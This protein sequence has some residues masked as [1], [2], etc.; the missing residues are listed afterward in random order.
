MEIS[1]LEAS[2]LQIS[3]MKPE[4]WPSS[5]QIQHPDLYYRQYIGA[6][7]DRKKLIYINAFCQDPPPQIWKS[8]IY[9][10]TDGGTCFWQAFYD[11]ATNQFSNLTINGRA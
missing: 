7:A 5:I 2:L 4:R 3:G 11:P 9:V 10:V 6:T 8:Q 1:G